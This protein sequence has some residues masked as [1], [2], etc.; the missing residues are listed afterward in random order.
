MNLKGGPSFDEAVYMV[1]SHEALV[2]STDPLSATQPVI[3]GEAIT[4][5]ASFSGAS[6]LNSHIFRIGGRAASGPDVSIG[7]LTFDGTSAVTGTE[8][9]DQAGT[10]GTT[11]ISGTYTV[12]PATGRASFIAGQGQNLG[13]HPF[14]AYVIPAP[15]NL[16]RTNCANPAACVTGFLVGTDSTAQDGILEFQTPS[17]A[18]PPPFSNLYVTGNYH[19]GTAESF[20]PLTP[21]LEGD[22]FAQPSGTSSTSGTL[23]LS[24]TSNG[25]GGTQDVSYGDASQF[26]VSNTLCYLLMPNQAPLGGSYTINSSGTGSFG[27]SAIVSVTNGNVIFYIDESPTNPHPS[28]I[29]AEQ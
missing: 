9:E 28:V 27:G 26:C 1:N 18:P 15:A 6:L 7:A 8:Y 4:T 16:S 5:A 12:D 24:T 29:V 19:Y 17:V 23:A 2:A 22:V 21:N 10:L 11:T 13:P 25:S 20:D 14:I 3:G